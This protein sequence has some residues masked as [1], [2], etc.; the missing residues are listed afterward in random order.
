M[1]ILAQKKTYNHIHNM[2]KN[3]YAYVVKRIV[4]EQVCTYS[5]R[6]DV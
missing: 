6:Y 4:K 5:L 2:N 3:Y 1:V